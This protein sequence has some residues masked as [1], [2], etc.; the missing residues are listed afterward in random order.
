MILIMSTNPVMGKRGPMKS[1]SYHWAINGDW[2]NS[3][4]FL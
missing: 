4:Q 3:G 2:A 1:G